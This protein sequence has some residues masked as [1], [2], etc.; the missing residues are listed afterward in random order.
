MVVVLV[1][2]LLSWCC[3]CLCLLCCRVANTAAT[4]TIGTPLPPP[5]PLGGKEDDTCYTNA[6]SSK[7]AQQQQGW[8]AIEG[9]GNKESDYNGNKGGE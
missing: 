9:R 1:V 7:A 3:H 6:N 8:Q 5:L 2:V 4:A